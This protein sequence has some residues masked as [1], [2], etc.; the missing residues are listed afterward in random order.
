MSSS[1]RRFSSESTGGLSRF[2]MRAKV[3]V[4]PPNATLRTFHEPAG[5]PRGFG[6]RQSSGAFGSG[7][8][9]QKRQRTAAV[10]DASAPAA[11]SS[12]F[13][14]PMHA[15]KRKEALSE[16][17]QTLRGVTSPEPLTTGHGPSTTDQRLTLGPRAVA[18]EKFLDPMIHRV[19]D[20]QVS[21]CVERHTPRVVE[22]SRR[23]ARAAEDFHRLTVHVKNLNPAVAELADELQALGVHLHVVGITHFPAARPRLP[24]RA[25]EFSVRRKSL[26]SMIARVGHVETVLGVDAQALGAVKL[27]ASAA[28]LTDDTNQLFSPGAELLHALGQSVFAHENLAVRIHHDRS[29]KSQFTG[30]GAMGAPLRD[31]FALGCK[32]VHARVMRF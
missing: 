27:A 32:V 12:R 10:Q 4:G 31:E 16:P 5:T 1:I 8:R 17:D 6:V 15:Q 21:F 11:A 22:L 23:R 13:M 25:E 24:V 30:I 19:G 28:A 7:P 2:S 29:R 18:S 20:V 26:N 9:A 14:V 3:A